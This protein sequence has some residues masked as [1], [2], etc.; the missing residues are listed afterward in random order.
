MPDIDPLPA[1]VVPA[2]PESVGFGR[3]LF[4]VREVEC[5][6]VNPLPSATRWY[7]I[8][9]ARSVAIAKAPTDAGCTLSDWAKPVAGSGLVAA[10][11]T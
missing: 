11:L 6:A 4:L 10:E 3:M 1:V 8:A 5:D 2:V 7:C 9:F